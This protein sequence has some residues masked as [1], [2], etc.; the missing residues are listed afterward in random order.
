MKVVSGK[1][2]RKIAKISVLCETTQQ[3]TEHMSIM[4]RRD[5]RLSV[6]VSGDLRDMFRTVYANW[7]D[8]NSFGQRSQTP[9]NV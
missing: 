6:K 5:P 1:T 9:S 7:S 2:F 8:C 4:W 3:S